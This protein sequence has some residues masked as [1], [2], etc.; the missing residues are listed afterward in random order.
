MATTSRSLLIFGSQIAYS[1]KAVNDIKTTLQNKLSRQW[2]LDTVAGLPKY[3]DALAEGLPKVTD[4]IGSQGRQLL[5]DLGPWLESNGSKTLGVQGDALPGVVFVPLIVLEQ[6]TEYRRYLRASST[7]NDDGGKS[8]PQAA[9]VASKTPA[10]GF[11]MGLLGAYGVASAH[12]LEELDRYGAVAVRLAMLAGALSDA[13]DTW[14]PHRT[15]AVAW[16]NVKQQQDLRRIVDSISPEAYISLLFDE[17]RATVTVTKRAAARFVRKARAAGVVLSDTGFRGELHSPKAQSKEQ[18]QDLVAFCD[19]RHDLQFAKTDH[20]ALTTFTNAGD[21]RPLAP[22]VDGSLHGHAL[23]TLFARQC[24]WYGTFAAVKAAYLNDSETSVTTTFG[25]DRCLPPTLVRNMGSRAVHFADVRERPSSPDH[26]NNSNNHNHNPVSDDAIAIVGMSIKVAG[27]DDLDEFSQLLRKGTSQHEKVTRERLNFDSLFREPDTRD[28]FCNFV[29]D[30]DAFDHR[31]FKRSPRESAAM[32]PQHRL[33]L[34]AAYQTVEQAGIFTEATR[35]G[36]EDR[37]RSHVGVYIGSPSVDYEHNVSTHPLN[38]LMATGNLQSYLPGRV[39]NHFGWTGPAIAFDTACSSSAV[40]IHTACNSLRNGECYA[41]LAGGVCI[42]TNPH[43]FQNLTAASFLSPTGQCKPFDEK[44]DGYCRAEGIACVLLKR[45]AD[46]R[47]DGNPILG[48]LASSAVYQ[49]Q[50]HTPIFVPNSPSLAQLFGDVIKKAHV[51]PR[52]IAL[53]E[54]HGTGTAVGDPAEWAALRKAVGGPIRP[55]PLPVGS[56]KGHIG[57]T[58]GTSGVISLIKVLMMMHE[59]YIPPQASFNKLNAAIRAAA[60]SDMMEIVTS[61]RSWDSRNKVALINNYGAS[62]SNAAMVVA[63]PPTPNER[64][65]VAS[66]KTLDGRFPFFISGSDARAVKAYAA[67]LAALVERRQSRSALADLSFNINRQSNP[68]LPQRFLLRC[69]SVDELRERLASVSEHDMTDTQAERPVVLCFGG[70]VSTFVGLD[71]KLYDSIAVFRHHLDGCDE[72]VQAELGLPSIFPDI[73][74]RTPLGDP[75]RLQVALFAMQYASAR[76]WIDCGLSG[77]VVSVVG[78]SFGELT[79]LCIS[80]ALSLKHALTLVSRRAQLVRD[81]WG[82]EKGSMMAV[83][84]DESLVQELLEHAGRQLDNP[85]TIA[86]YNGP[87]SFTLSG[88]VEAIDAVAEAIANNSDKFSALRSKRLNVTNA[89]HS[90][91]VDPLLDRLEQVGSELEFHE[92]SIPLERATETAFTG[93]LT[94]KFVPDHMRQ[95]VFFSHAM[96]R[97]AKKHPSAIFLEAGSSSTITVM[98]SR[99]LAGQASKSHHFESVSVTNEKGLD[100]LTDTTISLWKQGLRVAFWAH[101]TL[102]T[103]DYTYILLP[104]Y[105][106]EKARHWMDFKSATDLV[107]G[108][109]QKAAVSDPKTMPL[110]EFVGYQGNDTKHPRFRVNLV[111]D[112]FKKL[113]SGHVFAHTAPVLSGTV[114]SDMA[115]EALLSIHPDWKKQ[116]MIPT[117]LEA[118]IPTPI[119]VDSSRKVWI[120]YEALDAEHT[121]WQLNVSST[122]AEGTLPRRHLHGRLHIRW[123]SDPDFIAQF[124]RFERLVPYELCAKLLA[125]AGGPDVDVLQ[126]RQV[127]RAF[128]EF[129]EYSDQYNAMHAVVGKKNECAGRV[130]R[131]HAG[132]SFLDIALHDSFKQVSGLFLNCMSDAQPGEIHIGSDVELVMRSP[133][134][135]LQ[136]GQTQDVWHVYARHSQ[137]SAK[138]YM[139]DA[140]V[141]NAAN[142]E[143]VEVILGLQY[144]R[145]SIESMKRLLMN[146]TRDEWALN[147][148][149]SGATVAADPTPRKPQGV[150]GGSSKKP[151]EKQKAAK[152]ASSSQSP[153]SDLTME[154]KKVL[155]SVVGAEVDAITLDSEAADI[156][157]DSLMGIELLREVNSAFHCKLDLPELLAATTVGNIVTLVASALSQGAVEIAD[158]DDHDDDADD[159]VSESSLDDSRPTTSTSASELDS[160]TSG[161]D[162]PPIKHIH[163]EEQTKRDVTAREAEAERY[164]AEYTAGWTPAQ[165]SYTGEAIAGSHDAVII[166]T[167]ATGSLGAHVVA[168]LA[169]NPSVKTVVCLNRHRPTPVETRQDDAFSSRG[170]ALTPEARSKL[171]ILATD[172]SQPRLGLEASEYQWL[173]QHG[174]HIVHSAW[175]LSGSR[176]M[177]AFAPQFQVMRNL[178]DLARDMAVHRR[179]GFQMVSS[180]SVVGHAKERL[181]PE[182]RVHMDSVLPPGYGEAKW[183]CERMLDETLHKHPALFRAMAVRPAQIAGSAT[184]GVWNSVEQIPFIVKSAQSLGAWPNFRGTVRWIPVDAVAAILVDL[185]YIGDD[186]TAPDPWPIYHIDDPVGRPWEE[187]SSVL[188]DALDIPAGQFMPFKEWLDTVARSSKPETENPAGRLVDFLE[189]NF[190]RLSCG[191]LVLDTTKAQ[192]HSAAMR[193]LAPVSAEVARG[194]I[195]AWKEMGFLAS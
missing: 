9:L 175:P 167:G 169:S 147:M 110:W 161:V 66:I 28:Y 8:D 149:T 192:E 56:V 119:C 116:G 32:D 49:N 22:G 81:A 154:V 146:L 67:K 25:P 33:L 129:I 93:P 156:G 94:P 126:G 78:H 29:R 41:A 166:V 88:S 189:Q 72:I 80:G 35:A 114:Q 17:A 105:Q 60:D 144:T 55:Q 30:V 7:N 68:D 53:V 134:G 108:L 82:D 125:E 122:S 4:T 135:I 13:Q 176:P 120:D 15:Y 177:S 113:V 54:A 90:S 10:L 43:W 103:N 109:T 180:L 160:A 96:Q 83:E 187:I 12:D 31:F 174:S 63:A 137:V 170:I 97:L 131:R 153:K 3:W 98:A 185:L 184:S 84:A 141:F 40:A 101:H 190:E 168:A 20:L 115:V 102:Q 117:M 136:P 179:V 14:N 64:Q 159:D 193:A 132:E 121:L 21:G 51:S 37:D 163:S 73:F 45:M 99:A 44:G 52:D 6:L 16:T 151:Q 186:K 128:S 150:V 48:Q 95:P 91:L 86:C 26:N 1:E 148:S 100:G 75:V 158:D 50:N 24:D 195:R 171:R 70:Q 165:P 182:D 36:Q 130:H 172:S 23:E 2:V 11:C 27:A 46:A 164:V 87:R 39:A 107:A 181:V 178:L 65:D 188:A 5:E 191:G 112:K 142:G 133:R 127:Y 124:A 85:A 92:P 74:S 79:A 77:K 173:T 194:Y 111:S 152:K 183:V 34:Q 42:L 71:R 118:N 138:V 62:G 18:I 143:L 139:A 145:M 157:I 69:R 38:A 162:S 57:H 47:A 89:F 19:D 106:F 104:P 59:G 58:E 123:P 61:L 140:F 76:S 155:A